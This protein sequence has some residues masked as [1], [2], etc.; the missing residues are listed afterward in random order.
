M[1]SEEEK[2]LVQEVI[3]HILY[4][5]VKYQEE[6]KKDRRNKEIIKALTAR[7]VKKPK[8]KPLRDE[9]GRFKKAEEPAAPPLAPAPPAPTT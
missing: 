1:K 3:N 6:L 4:C 7:K 2:Q 9:K 5:D 8:V